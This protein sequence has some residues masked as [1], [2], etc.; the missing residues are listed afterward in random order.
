[1]A[2][3]R[4]YLE[5]PACRLLTLV[6]P[7]GMGKTR[8]ALETVSGWISRLREDELEGATLVSLAPLQTVEAIVPAIAQAIGLQ[9]SA[10]REPAEQLLDTLARKRRLLILDGFEHLP[11]GAGLVAEILSTTATVKILVT[12]RVRLALQGETCLPVA[13]IAFPDGIPGAAQEA[14]SFAAVDLFLQ[15]THRVR[16][17]FQPDGEDLAGI[18]RIC[19]LVHGMPL[20]ILLAAAWMGVLGPDEIAAEIGKSLDFLRAD[21]PEVPE[22]QRSIRAV[23][24]GSWVLLSDRQREVAQALSVFSGGFTRAA[25]EQVGG[26]SLHEL[27]ALADRSWLQVTPSGRYQIHE[28][29]LQYAAERLASAPDAFR[30]VHDRA[31]AFYIDALAGWGADLLGARQQAALVEAEAESGNIRAAWGWAVSRG[32]VE[33][34]DRAM[35]ALE[36]FYWESG[37]YREA[38]AALAAAAAAASGAAAGEPAAGDRGA[39]RATCLRVRVRALA[40][41]S[42]FLRAMGQKEAACRIQQQCLRILQ[43]AGPAGADTRLERALLAW[44]IGVTSCMADYEEGRQQFEKSY[45][46]FR[47]VD[48]RWGMARALNAWG[49]MSLYLGD[50]AEAR[51]RLEEGLAIDRAL[52]NRLGIG[53]AVSRLACLAGLEGRF[54]EA[55]GLAR[56]G[57]AVS[58][59]AGGRTQTA[60]ALLDLGEVLEAAGKS[61]DAQAPLAQSLA[62]L[63]DLGHR[64]YITQAHVLLGSVGLHLGRYQEAGERA[65]TALALARE[66][67]PRFC[68][69]DALLLQGCL[70][71]ARGAPAAA[72]PLLEEGAAV[73]LELSQKD[74]LG[75]ALACLALSACAAGDAQEGRQ[76]LG[77]ALEA[78]VGSGAVAPLLWGLAAAA[79]LLAGEGEAE[80]AVGL[81][82]LASRYGLVAGSRWFADVV[83]DRVGALAAGLP[84]L[85]TA[86]GQGR[87]LQA[88]AVELLRELR[89]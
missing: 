24:D 8:L 85:V 69:G 15:A 10:G 46:L 76:H 79:L 57:V 68:A 25:A 89:P 29:L 49:T 19:R 84:V 4:A 14:R 64:G 86:G 47:E 41:Q 55:E 59:D 33:R 38:E 45:A 34:L 67:G 65:G 30:A 75:V 2:Q 31:C 53:G 20:G 5:D 71:L 77:L 16:P 1:M 74:D 6:G 61:A 32:Q 70:A 40:W 66:H 52:G 12:S 56:E 54:A 88:A 44:T 21:W 60:L 43:D 11:D 28:M 83:G 78:A 62:L 7:G 37:R 87:D 39:D 36:Q 80:R 23:F 51:R 3:I 63:D 9:L 48:H 81:Y 35:E 27:R 50:Y 58:R 26:A 17:G 22:R 18:S 72:R 13:G 42:N 73:Y 82:A